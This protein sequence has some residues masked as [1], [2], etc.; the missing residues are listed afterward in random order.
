[1]NDRTLAFAPDVV[2]QT[3]DGEGLL[4]GLH[5]EVVFSLN[6]SGARIVELIAEGRGVSAIV[7]TLS[8][9]YECPRDEIVEDVQQLIDSLRTRGLIVQGT[10]ETR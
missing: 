2:F 1:M 6:A 7:D 8:T 3:I 4:L 5:N 10:G 9:E